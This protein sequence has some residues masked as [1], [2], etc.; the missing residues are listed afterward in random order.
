M[1]YS[2]L[3]YIFGGGEL[4]REVPKDSNI[5]YIC[6]TDDETLQSD[7]WTIV[8]DED[9]KDMT[10]LHASFYVRHHPFKYCTGD[11][12][13]RVDGSVQIKKS[14]LPIFE[15]FEAS[16][17]DMCVMTNSRAFNIMFEMFQWFGYSDIIAKQFNM[18]KQLNIPTLKTG[19]LQ[20]TFSIVKNN[21]TCNACDEL[22]W[23]WIN[24]LAKNCNKVRPSQALMTAAVYL[25]PELDL[26]FV[27]E[28]LIQSNYMQ[29]YHHNSDRIRK[30]KRILNHSKFFGEPIKIH[31]FE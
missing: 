23:S 27:D 14:L 8:I 17:K 29:W 16:G 5:E 1:K 3:T 9:L 4:L 7:S 13:I 25:T 6:V 21:D 26:M 10:P 19:S 12:C 15:E 24:E 28:N 18:Y 11:I 22:C 30:S 31:C 20:A 2:V